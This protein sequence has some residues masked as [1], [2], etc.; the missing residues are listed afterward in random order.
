MSWVFYAVAAFTGVLVKTVDYFEDDRK[1]ISP[2]KYV[3]AILYG[4]LIGFVISFSTFATLWLSVLF[5]QLITGKIDKMSHFLGFII[6][7]IVAVAFGVGDF[8]PLDFFVLL[9]VASFDEVNP[10]SWAGWNLRPGLKLAT[11]VFGM[12]G[13]W[14]YF[15]AI[16]SFDMMYHLVGKILSSTKSNGNGETQQQTQAA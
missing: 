3:L 7:L 11:L 4:V 1:W 15:F 14:D 10:F 13:R 5:A 16:I 9:A 6:S 8:V 12:L 2:L